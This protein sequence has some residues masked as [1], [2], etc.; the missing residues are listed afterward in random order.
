MLELTTTA[1][2]PLPIEEGG[3]LATWA[4]IV[5]ALLVSFAVI[6]TALSFLRRFLI[7]LTIHFKQLS[8]KQF[9]LIELIIGGSYITFLYL[10]G[11]ERINVNYCCEVPLHR[12]K[13]F[14]MGM[15]LVSTRHDFTIRS[16][17]KPLH[18]RL[19]PFAELN[20]L[21]ILRACMPIQLIQF[22]D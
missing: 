7:R 16:K 10:G 4:I 8:S 11:G 5:V 9:I 20:I 6:L 22:S 3:G 15:V 13:D 2:P 1:L 17:I 21:I 19:C 14:F 18:I 12:L